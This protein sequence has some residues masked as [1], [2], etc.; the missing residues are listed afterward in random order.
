MSHD[1]SNTFS[2]SY[3]FNCQNDCDD[4]HDENDQNGQNAHENAHVDVAAEGE[5]G[6]NGFLDDLANW[7]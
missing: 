3:V 4:F 5:N 2:N 1:V 7:N 6:E